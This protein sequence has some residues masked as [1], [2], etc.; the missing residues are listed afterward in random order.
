DWG[1][2]DAFYSAAIAVTTVGFGDLTSSTDASKLF[3]VAY[4]FCGIAVISLFVNQTLRRH[5][6]RMASRH[7]SP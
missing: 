7:G 5:A 2:V 1:W 6:R 4:I 3:T